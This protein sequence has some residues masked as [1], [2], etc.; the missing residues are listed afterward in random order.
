MGR[1][2][3]CS[4]AQALVA[5]NAAAA[6]R[7]ARAAMDGRTLNRPV[8]CASIKTAEKTVNPERARIRFEHGSE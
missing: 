2:A 6:K 7:P 5:V 3:A 1:K 4:V 8:G